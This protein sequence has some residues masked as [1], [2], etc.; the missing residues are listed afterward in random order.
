MLAGTALLVTG[1]SPS[2]IA[3]QL[4]ISAQMQQTAIVL[5]DGSSGP[6]NISP[7]KQGWLTFGGFA[8]SKFPAMELPV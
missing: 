5:Y 7:E 3:A 8:T 1:F 2:S 4:A 6:G